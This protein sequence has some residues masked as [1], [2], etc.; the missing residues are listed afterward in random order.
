MSPDLRQSVTFSRF[1]VSVSVSVSVSP[2][3]PFRVVVEARGEEV[4][5]DIR[6][7]LVDCVETIL[8]DSHKALPFGSA[9]TKQHQCSQ[10][11]SADCDIFQR[12]CREKVSFINENTPRAPTGP[13]NTRKPARLAS[14]SH[15]GTNKLK[16]R[17]MDSRSAE[18]Q[19]IPAYM[20]LRI[21]IGMPNF[22]M[23]NLD[24]VNHCTSKEMPNLDS[25]NHCTSK[26][27]SRF[28]ISKF[29]IPIE[30]RSTV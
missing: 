13:K 4:A 10:L 15:R 1:L 20:R 18:A 21:S 14:N 17:K 2:F 28:S 6:D 30:I 19:P 25:V 22:E 24:S 9:L 3:L 26:T 16:T 8:H 29:G 7:L 11:P 27:E 12:S 23:P 5:S